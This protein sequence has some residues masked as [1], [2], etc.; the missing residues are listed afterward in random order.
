VEGSGE[1]IHARNID[2]RI[3][4]TGEDILAVEGKLQDERFF[5]SFIEE[6]DIFFDSGRIHDIILRIKIRV[7][8]ATIIFAEAKMP[9]SPVKECEDT[10]ERIRELKGLSL[11]TGFQRHVRNIM[12][13]NKGCLHLMEL[14]YSMGAAAMQGIWT[15]SSRVRTGNQIKALDIDPRYVGDSCKVWRKDGL[16]YSK[17]IKRLDKASE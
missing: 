4:E 5:Q 1:L 14:V 10:L 12:K 6:R 13:G 8:D 15:Y 17:L 16:Y 9:I 2:I 3:Y 7:P 11:L